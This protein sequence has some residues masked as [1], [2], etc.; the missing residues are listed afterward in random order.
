MKFTVNYM[1]TKDWIPPRCRKPRPGTFE[2]SIEVEVAEI[3]ASD[4]PWACVVYSGH[5][6]TPMR[7]YDGKF[8]K[9]ATRHVD[10]GFKLSSWDID[11]Y[12]K[13]YVWCKYDSHRTNQVIG[14]SVED[15]V[16]DV[17]YKCEWYS[18]RSALDN[19]N[20]IKESAARYIVVNGEPWKECGEP[21]YEIATFGLGHN[22][23]GTSWFVQDSYNSNVSKTRYFNACDFDHMVERFFE[24]ALGRGDTDDAHRHAAEL[25]RGL[26]REGHYCY[27][28]I[29]V[30]DP[31]VFMR[32]PQ[33]EHGDGD[34]FLNML[35]D[36][37]E[38][39][40]NATEAGLLAMAAALKAR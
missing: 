37:T 14:M 5:D 8:Y 20:A 15:M 36:I 9:R 22:H 21:M 16:E 26:V 10:Y 32:N 19:I 39:S 27:G 1:Y 40:D 28:F 13:S 2:D 38:N 30:I 24:I 6:V 12:G 11:S 23:G 7:H 3:R 17:S 25:A 31:S 33:V 18:H 35:Y 4:A 29:E 34:P